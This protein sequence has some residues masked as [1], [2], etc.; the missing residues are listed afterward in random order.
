MFQCSC[1]N[2]STLL[3]DNFKAIKCP[4]KNPS[5]VLNR[6]R[7]L[8]K[9]FLQ[10][11]GLLESLRYLLIIGYI[12]EPC[13]WVNLTS[14]VDDFTQHKSI[15]IFGIF[16]V[17]WNSCTITMLLFDKWIKWKPLYSIQLNARFLWLWIKLQMKPL[18]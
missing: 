11:N 6:Y 4:H 7:K 9:H 10:V 13:K 1:K 14:Q 8:D 2:R 12:G 16:C 18:T 17:V 5:R 3:C 15:S